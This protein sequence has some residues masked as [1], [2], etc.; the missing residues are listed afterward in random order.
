M[1]DRMPMAYWDKPTIDLAIT[2]PPEAAN[3][4][5]GYIRVSR[6]NVVV[7]LHRWI[8]EQLKG[9]IPIGHEIDHRNKIKTD[10]ELD[11]LRCIKQEFN[12]RN[13]SKRSDNTSGIT[14]V[15]VWRNR[16]WRAVTYGHITHKQKC[17]VFSIIKYGYTT[18]FYMAIDARNDMIEEL[19]LN[20]AG[21]SP[22]HGE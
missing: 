6:N 13:Q 11:N 20:G 1:K 7:Y 8:W 14:G 17:K 3:S 16:F 2:H 18:A 15:S 19:N 4:V 9:P 5:S 10:C 12:L 22:H 21:Y